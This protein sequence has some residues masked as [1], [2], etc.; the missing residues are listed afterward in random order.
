MTAL[1]ARSIGY[2]VHVLD[3]DPACAAAPVVE[4]LLAAP[5][6]D[7]RAAAALARGSSV[8]TL[9]I[10][11]IAPAALAAAAEQAPLRP[12]PGVIHLVQDRVRQKRWLAGRGFP[13]GPFREAASE[14]EFVA[15]VETFGG[16]VFAKSSFGGY[17]GRGQARLDEDAEGGGRQALLAGTEAG[18]DAAA[19]RRAE[20]ARAA[21]R[22]VGEGACVV[23]EALALEAELSVLVAR[24]TDG[25][26][27]AYPPA[28]NHHVERI[29]DWSLLPGGFD[30]PLVERAGALARGIAEALELEGLLCVELFLT[31]DG[32]LLVNEL[33]PRPHNSYHGSDVACPTGQ[34][35]QLVRAVCGLPLGAVEPA[36]P[37]A[38]VNLLG[39][40]WGGDAPPDFA[41]ALAVPGV[42]LVLYG[43]GEP[44]PGRKMGHLVALAETAE[45]ALARAR[46]GRARLGHGARKPFSV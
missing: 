39:D 13:V 16:R 1:A 30:P 46:E 2:R 34:F 23:E 29:L 35:E 19:E 27:V 6:D 14:E 41:A 25:A 31:R 26:T 3:P 33:A 37:T 21:W 42:R 18:T 28:K 8:V 43:K 20:G 5:F 45:G 10:E 32:R 24:G 40:L 7:A 17:D 11:K 9:E 15:A 38:I 12:A 36:R 4:R 44:R 22:A